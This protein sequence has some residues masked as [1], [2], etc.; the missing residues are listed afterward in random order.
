MRIAIYRVC[1]LF[2][3]IDV[4]DINL[5][6]AFS[7]QSSFLSKLVTRDVYLKFI[8][9][10]SA[11]NANQWLLPWMG[12]SMRADREYTYLTKRQ[13]ERLHASLSGHTGAITLLWSA[14]SNPSKSHFRTILKQMSRIS[15]FLQP[16]RR[17]L[18]PR[19]I[20]YWS[21]YVCISSQGRILSLSYSIWL[22]KRWLPVS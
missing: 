8:E 6:I 7:I 12:L 19:T 15:L 16:Q 5:V 1:Y 20:H 11:W 4:C 22:S 2:E 17:I 13:K 14:K 21:T 9:S 3:K 10:C 18:L